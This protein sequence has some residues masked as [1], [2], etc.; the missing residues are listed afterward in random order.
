MKEVQVYTDGACSGN[1]GPGGWGAIL[2]YQGNERELSGGEKETT[3]NRM[4]LTAAIK[5][6]AALKESCIV[7]L[8]S[9]SKYLVDAISL[10]WMEKWRKN[11]WKKPDGNSALNVDLW[12]ELIIQLQRHQVKLHWIKGHAGHPKN[13]RCDML[14]TSEIKKYKI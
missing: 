7:D 4:E 2:H 14:A 5:G 1:P 13:E 6:L 12:K 10:G 11:N 9:D 8:Y 3:N